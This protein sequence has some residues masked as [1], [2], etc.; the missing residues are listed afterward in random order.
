[1]KNEFPFETLLK[2]LLSELKSAL[3]CAN[4][5]TLE[6]LVRDTVNK[7]EEFLKN[8]PTDL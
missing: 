8:H 4:L 3:K 7:I 2:Y 6:Y 5:K 1:M